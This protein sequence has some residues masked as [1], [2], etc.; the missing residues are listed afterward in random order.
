MRPHAPERAWICAATLLCF[1][2]MA[3]LAPAALAA[4]AEDPLLRDVTELVRIPSVSALPEHAKDVRAAAEW[5]V[6]RLKRTPGGVFAS[7]RVEE[8][9]AQERLTTAQTPT[10]NHHMSDSVQLGAL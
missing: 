5:F 9:G 10:A 2:A 1:A 4:A 7:V 8:T 6:A 3:P